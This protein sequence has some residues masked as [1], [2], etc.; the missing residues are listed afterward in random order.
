MEDKSLPCQ[1]LDLWGEQN[2]SQ[3]GIKHIVSRKQKKVPKKFRDRA[4]L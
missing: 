2:H 3:N 4:S 1:K